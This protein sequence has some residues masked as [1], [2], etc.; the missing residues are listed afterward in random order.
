MT[1]DC[2]ILCSYS[3][4]EQQTQC[5]Q[6]PFS[7]EVGNSTMLPLNFLPPPPSPSH[8]MDSLAI[9]QLNSWLRTK[10][11]T[12]Y[13]CSKFKIIVIKPEWNAGDLDLGKREKLTSYVGKVQYHEWLVL[14]DDEQQPTKESTSQE[15]TS[16]LEGVSFAGQHSWASQQGLP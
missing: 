9:K 1:P 3:G 10:L 14:P 7:K 2:V 12:L 16:R 15:S 6:S 4:A 13:C 5:L 8:S 11:I